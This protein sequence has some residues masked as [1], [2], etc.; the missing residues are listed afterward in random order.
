MS[1]TVALM[2]L[3]VFV[4]HSDK[5]CDCPTQDEDQESVTRS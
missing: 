3:F 1:E 2:H 5:I 4:I